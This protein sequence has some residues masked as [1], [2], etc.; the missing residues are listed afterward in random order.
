MGALP[1]SRYE[2]RRDDT[3]M[4]E[5]VQALWRVIEPWLAAEALELDDLELVGAGRG[6][7]L[8]VAVDAEG[9]LDLDRL[10]EVSEGIS[11]LLDAQADIAGPYQLEVTT[12]GL[13][14]KLRRLRHW[15]K[16]I[17]REVAVKVEGEGESVRGILTAAGPDGFSVDA[18]EGSRY[19]TY[20]QV[21]SAKTLFRWEAAPKPGK[22]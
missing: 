20:H 15:E 7:T 5:H 21:V 3:A 11:R 16:S 17:G 8:R 22:K 1:T 13:E 19:Y 10:A 2:T 14:R 9:G 18:G 6:L 4:T 12:P